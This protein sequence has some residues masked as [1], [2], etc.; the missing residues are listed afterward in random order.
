MF[1]SLKRTTA[2]ITVEISNRYWFLSCYLLPDQKKWELKYPLGDEN[3]DPWG[4]RHKDIDQV[5]L[6]AVEEH[7][8]GSHA[9]GAHCNAVSFPNP[10]SVLQQQ[11]MGRTRSDPTSAKQ[12]E[13]GEAMA[14]LPSSGQQWKPSPCLRSKKQMEMCQEKGKKGDG[15][16]GRCTGRKRYVALKHRGYHFLNGGESKMYSFHRTAKRWKLKMCKMTCVIRN[17][18]SVLYTGN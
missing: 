1:C 9:S 18:I 11:K 4:C 16:A 13:V 10:G 5:S 17:S 12:A 8:A 3:K 14:N 2:L 6:C 7:S 15:S